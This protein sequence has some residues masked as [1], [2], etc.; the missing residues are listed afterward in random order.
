MNAAYR[1][2]NKHF[3][4]VKHQHEDEEQ[5]PSGYHIRNDK[6]EATRENRQEQ[7]AKQRMAKHVTIGLELDTTLDTSSSVDK[8]TDEFAV[9]ADEFL[10]AAEPTQPTQPSSSNVLDGMEIIDLTGSAQL[11]GEGS[12]QAGSQCV[13]RW[14]ETA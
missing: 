5:S 8:Q 9:L 2:R 6:G 7:I 13:C 12:R 14:A 10:Q 1:T 11:E 4:S 3:A